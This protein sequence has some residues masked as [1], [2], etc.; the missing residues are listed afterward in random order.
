MPITQLIYCSRPRLIDG[1]QK[2][3]LAS[4]VATATRLNRING[5]TGCLGY[6]QSWFLQV[7]EGPDAAVTETF[8]RIE[9]DSRHSDVRKLLI[10]EIRNRSFPEW[11]MA[12]APLDESAASGRGGSALSP[13]TTPPLQLLMWMMNVA[14]KM[15]MQR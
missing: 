8:S 2:D 9:R 13:D 15:R 11:S 12:S 4:I 3:A 14:D 10:R 6:S 1:G 5:I 7:I